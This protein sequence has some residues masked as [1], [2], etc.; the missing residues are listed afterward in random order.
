MNKLNKMILDALNTPYGVARD[1]KFIRCRK[2]A[3]KLQQ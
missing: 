2:L 3:K 1:L